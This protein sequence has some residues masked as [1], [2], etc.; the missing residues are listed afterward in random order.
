MIFSLDQAK[1]L[2]RNVGME[3][4]G[5][6]GRGTL[7]ALFVKSGCPRVRAEELGLAANVHFRTYG[8][9]ASPLRLAHFM[10]QVG[11]ESGGFVYMEEIASGSAYEGRLD[12]GNTRPGDGKLF[13]GRGPIQLTGRSNYRVYGRAIGIDIESHPELVAVPSFGLWIACKFWN[14]RGLNALADDDN[15]IAIT[16]SINGGAN[17]LADRRSRLKKAK[18]LVG[19]AA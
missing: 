19:V 5:D 18:A 8:I 11:H 1:T 4:D 9:L 2:Q 6:I 10:A 17:G 3:T 13:K 7:S 12:L 14:D 15:E 16:K